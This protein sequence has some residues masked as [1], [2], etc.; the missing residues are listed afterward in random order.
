VTSDLA[1]LQLVY[2]PHDGQKD[3][4]ASNAKY[5]VMEVARRWGKSRAAL[6]ELLKTYIELLEVPAPPSLVP[7]F[8]A[9]IVCPSFP[10]SRQTWNELQAF[11][12][13]VL[14]HDYPK[15][16]KQDEKVVYLRG[17]DARPWGL[18]E[19][20]SADNEQALQTV[21]LDFLW[22]NES[23]EISNAAFEKLAPILTSSDRLGRA[24]FEGIPAL[25]PDHWFWRLY[26]LA[27]SEEENNWDAFKFTAFENPLLNDEQ[28]KEIERYREIMPD[29]AWRR[30]FLAERSENAGYFS[31]I[32]PAIKGDMLPNPIPGVRYVAG[33]DLGRKRDPS[34]LTIIEPHTHRVVHVDSW[35]ENTGWITQ[36]ETIANYVHTWNIERIA[37]D[38]TS[39]G[40]DMFTEELQAQSLPVEPYVI[41][42]AQAREQ[43]L[44]GLVI[45][46]ERQTVSFPHIPSLVRELRSFQYRKTPSG[47][48]R[49]EVPPG[50]HDDHVF[51]LALAL[52]VCDDIQGNLTGI[53]NLGPM[54]YLPTQEEMKSGRIHRSN[55]ARMMAR[56]LS[57]KIVERADRMGV[58]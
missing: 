23:Q 11:I 43:L 54:R 55:G 17:S 1:D 22:V 39:L 37:I 28:K 18:I 13:P 7:P 53:P 51:S 49:P 12:P 34:V 3:V 46:L 2:E 33:L 45:A 57:D 10:Q 15:G 50:E 48:I 25:W 21:G 47:H 41:G 24:I 19:I 20:K 4:H 6:F 8:H 9:W 58:R 40:G 26:D 27:T 5:K 35:G 14:V 42:S 16:F 32:T 36:R 44:S 38:A 31:N 52:R 29:L 30:M 56:R